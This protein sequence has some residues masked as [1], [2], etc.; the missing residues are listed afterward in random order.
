MLTLCKKSRWFKGFACNDKEPAILPRLHLKVTTK[1]LKYFLAC[2]L[3]LILKLFFTAF[4]VRDPWSTEKSNDPRLDKWEKGSECEQRM[5]QPVDGSIG[6]AAHTHGFSRKM[7]RKPYLI[8]D[9]SKTS[10]KSLCSGDSAFRH[11]ADIARQQIER[12]I[13]D[14]RRKRLG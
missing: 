14:Q 12:T 8:R 11:D 3:D 9:Q 6:R 10:C 2:S 13:K 5:H 7:I 1:D 4:A